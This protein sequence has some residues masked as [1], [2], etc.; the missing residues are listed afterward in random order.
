MKEI[1]IGLLFAVFWASASVATKIGLQSAE[2]F[3][4]TNTRF[5]LAALL[6][7]VW[8]HLV[9]RYPLPKR[10]EFRPLLVY[11]LLNASIYLGVFSWA[12]RYATA[13]LGSLSVALNPLLIAIISAFFLKKKVDKAVWAGLLM[14][15]IGVGI[16]TFPVLRDSTATPLG[17]SLL[18]SSMLS[19]S[20]GTVYFSKLS[21][22]IPR[23]VINGWQVLFGALTLLPVT[24]WFSDWERHEWGLPFWGSV[25]WL[26]VPVSI[27]AVQLWLYL[28]HRDPVK[29]ALW[30]YLCPILG[31]FYAWLLVG[32]SI[33][34]YTGVGT[35]LVI[36]GLYSGQ[37][38]P[39]TVNTRAN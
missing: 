35:V 21:W 39:K 15:I 37:R 3:V 13:G 7:L 33:T 20:L 28:L 31:F 25:L 30:L 34:L 14:G 19:Y 10:S 2:P 11:G 6:M 4:I 9:R 27:G 12:M 36:W 32:E 26:A 8:A 38:S 1:L 23:L 24:L 18:F 16:V 29:A 5:I 22:S 17:V